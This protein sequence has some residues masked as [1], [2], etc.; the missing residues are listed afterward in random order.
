MKV[1]SQEE[2]IMEIFVSPWER[3]PTSSISSV[4]LREEEPFY[5]WDIDEAYLK[6]VEASFDDP[7][8]ADSR[9][10]SGVRGRESSGAHRRRSHRQPVRRL[11]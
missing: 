1:E 4:A 10:S 6:R 11:G 8:F 2:N 5:G 3:I 7:R 9:L